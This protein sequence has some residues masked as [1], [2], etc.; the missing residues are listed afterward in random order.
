MKFLAKPSFI[1]AI[2]LFFITPVGY[3]QKQ[4][5]PYH[6]V[7]SI[8]GKQKIRGVITD[9][10]NTAITL[11]DKKN[12][13]HQA[14]FSNINRI[15]VYKRHKDIGY[16]VI[17][18]ALVA[19]NIVLAQSL[20]DGNVAL[21]V[22]TAGTIGIVSLAMLLHNAIHGPELTIKAHKEQMDYQN[23]SQKLAPY[24]VKEVSLTP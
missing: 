24:V 14:T 11:I 9:I 7:V 17:T 12:I 3:A 6:A 5:L 10:N 23:L 19:G 4:S 21:L 8:E 18:G 22:G 15:K 16:A 20:D 2:T 13:V 1:I